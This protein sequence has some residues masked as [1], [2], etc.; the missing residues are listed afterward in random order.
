MFRNKL[1]VQVFI[2]LLIIGGANSAQ[3]Y[4]ANIHK[5]EINKLILAIQNSECDF[6]R[7]DKRYSPQDAAKHLRL[8]WKR[9][10][11]Y[12]NT[13]EQF[14]INLASFSS[15]SKRPYLIDCG[16]QEN[17]PIRPWLESTLEQIRQ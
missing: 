4:E 3:V 15:F 10:E 14:I 12:A 17:Q 13:A 16:N 2:L 5:E 7:N 1:A 9:G 8:K 11:K 6:Y